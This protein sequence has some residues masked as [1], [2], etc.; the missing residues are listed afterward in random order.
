MIHVGRRN[1]VRS[2]INLAN[3]M[4]VIPCRN[5]FQSSSHTH[6]TRHTTHTHTHTTHNTFPVGTVF[7]DII[8]RFNVGKP[9]HASVMATLYRRGWIT[10]L[11]GDDDAALQHLEKALIICQLNEPHR[12][13]EYS[14]GC[15][16]FTSAKAWLKRQIG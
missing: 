7:F 4:A 11:Q 8:E 9:T 2:S 13:N 15:R 16:R 6:S 5:S 12:G 14:G 1:C 3:K 10:L